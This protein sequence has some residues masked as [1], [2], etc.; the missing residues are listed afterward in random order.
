MWSR[1]EVGSVP[2]L[3][4]RI[5]QT[6]GSDDQQMVPSGWTRIRSE[7]SPGVFD[8]ALHAVVVAAEGGSGHRPDALLGWRS[9]QPGDLQD[10]LRVE[11][12]VR[13]QRGG[14]RVELAPP[15]LQQLHRLGIR[16]L[17]DPPDFGVNQACRVVAVRSPAGQT[18][19]L[20]RFTDGAIAARE[21]HRTQLIAH[22]PASDHLA[23]NRRGL[24]HIALRP[25][26]ARTVDHV[27]SAAF[28]VRDSLALCLIQHNRSGRSKRDRFQRVQK[29]LQVDGVFIASG[30]Q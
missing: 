12:L 19:P 28:V 24:L 2:D 21:R 13:E 22:A 16:V 17:Q 7:P 18:R 15:C 11:R 1:G 27:L 5:W 25:R 4:G 9:S 14:E 3:P 20:V 30:R 29:I 10:F 6:W 23:R 26:G 8:A